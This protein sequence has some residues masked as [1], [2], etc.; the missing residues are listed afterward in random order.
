MQL[1]SEG[2]SQRVYGLV[3]RH[4]QAARISQPYRR[5]PVAVGVAAAECGGGPSFR[6]LQRVHV[7]GR[8]GAP[9]S[10][11][12]SP[13]SHGQDMHQRSTSF[14]CCACSI[15]CGKFSIVVNSKHGMMAYVDDNDRFQ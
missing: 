8:P 11:P 10:A 4:C 7:P 14:C 12:K 3:L 15:E 2:K 6:A 5:A 9:L 13:Q 1:P